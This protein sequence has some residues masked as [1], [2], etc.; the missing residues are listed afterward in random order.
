M[1]TVCLLTRVSVLHSVITDIWLYSPNS[2]E[3][4]FFPAVHECFRSPMYVT[5]VV[6]L[7][8]CEFLRVHGKSEKNAKNACDT[9][10]HRRSIE[11]TMY[12]LSYKWTRQVSASLAWYASKISNATKSEDPARLRS[13]NPW[14]SAARPSRRGKL[15]NKFFFFF[16][17]FLNTCT[18]QRARNETK[19]HRRSILHKLHHTAGNK[20]Y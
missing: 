18:K 10:N 8:N 13:R 9:R 3:N 19:E 14:K 16:F 4:I 12:V 11:F 15:F 7:L 17:F 20:R 5:F 1:S 6:P 2:M